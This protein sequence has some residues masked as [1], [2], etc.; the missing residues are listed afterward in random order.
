MRTGSIHVVDLVYQH[1]ADKLTLTDM[2]AQTYVSPSHLSRSIKKTVGL[3]FSEILSLAR[4]EEVERLLFTTNKTVDEIADQVGFANR[5]HLAINFKKWYKK[6][7]TAFRQTLQKDQRL[8]HQPF[9]RT[10]DE[11]RAK[12][13][14]EE[15][16]QGK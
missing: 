14:L 16:N 13:A 7:P 3:T 4:S 11:A 2:A 8:T 5:K 12:N 10:V 9:L 6:T 15:W 1:F